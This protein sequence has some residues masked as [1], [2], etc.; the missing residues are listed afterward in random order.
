M[1]DPFPP[2]AP[3]QFPGQLPPQPPG[4]TPPPPGPPP[5][6]PPAPAPLPWEQPGYPFLEALFETGKLFLTSPTEAFKRM[7]V[8][9]DLGRPLIYAVIL[10]W[11]GII[12]GQ[13]YN[14]AFRSAMMPL[15]APFAHHGMGLGFGMGVAVN[16]AV[17]IA[18]PVLILLGLFIGG[19]IVHLFLLMV[20]GAN[21]GFAATIRVMCYATTV[22]VLQVI[23]LCGGLIGAVWA[24]VLEIIGLAIAHRTTQGKAAVAVLLPLALCCACVALL[25]AVAGA[26]IMAAISRAAH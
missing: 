10:G 8:A 4:Q 12:A 24:I 16:V 23:P 18:A 17:M 5:T 11:V 6:P 15:L 21:S 22:H 2:P 25:F 26:A 1:A 7:S 9:G 3:P 19:A 14:I 20:G 13:L